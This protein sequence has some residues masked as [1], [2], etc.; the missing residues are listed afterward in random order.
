G[1]EHSKQKDQPDQDDD[2]L[3]KE[4]TFRLKA[5]DTLEGKQRPNITGKPIRVN[6]HVAQWAAQGVIVSQGGNRQGYTLFARDGKA[7]FTIRRDGEQTEVVSDTVLEPGKPARLMGALRADG[8]VV[9]RVNK[10]KP[11]KGKAAGLLPGT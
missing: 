9:L 5:N 7:V 6:A 2:D 4:T 8:S 1:W 10:G 3:S 11:A